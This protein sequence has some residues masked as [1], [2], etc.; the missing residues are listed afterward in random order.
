MTTERILPAVALP[1]PGLPRARGGAPARPAPGPRPSGATHPAERAARP[2]GAR[3]EA[4]LST[5]IRA[6]M[7]IGASAAIYAVSLA[8]VSGLQYQSEMDLAAQNQPMLDTIAQARAA[9]DALQASILAA[10]ARTQAVA[11]DYGAAGK[12]M[13]AY[14][15]QLDNLSQ[16]V[17]RVQGSAA[18]L[19]TKISLPAVSIHGSVGG[20]RSAPATTATTSASA[21]P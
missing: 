9:N 19:S 2:A 17:A 14:Q 21:K 20:S 6:G 7:L 5:P 12:D 1:S 3:K 13:A 11:A 4:I 8:A 16:L 15:A 18:A 10:G